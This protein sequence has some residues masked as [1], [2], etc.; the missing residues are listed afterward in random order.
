MKLQQQIAQNLIEIGAVGF[1]PQQPI[2]FKSG[3]LS[4]VYID[5][6][7]F[8]Y[9]PKAWHLVLQA[10][11]QKLLDEKINFDIVAGVEAAGIPH[12]AA[13]GY[14]M[15][16]ASIFVRKKAKDH[17]TKNRI[18]GGNVQDKTVILIEDHITMG[19][20]SLSVVKALREAGA[21][22]T[23][24][25]AI[26]SYD[27]AQAKE[28]FKQA[29]VNLH[30]LVPFPVILDTALAMNKFQ[31]PEKD[32]ISNWYQDPFNWKAAYVNN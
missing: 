32:L 9:Y 4:P 25:L 1:V 26:T 18:E 31:Q 5:N 20:S 28:A 27:F 30:I 3:I 15:N 8:P 6:R 7:K 22:V 14:L 12:S 19:G 24:C 21:K 13:L 10:F 17:G 2:T 23:D 11:E 29:K 16:K